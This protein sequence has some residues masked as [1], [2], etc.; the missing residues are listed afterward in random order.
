MPNDPAYLRD[1]WTRTWAGLGTR[2]ADGVLE[3]LLARYEEKHRAYHTL[4]HLTECLSMREKLGRECT[5]PAEVDLALF[6]HDAIYEPMRSDNEA[7]SAAWLDYVATGA[8]LAPDV[9]DRLRA[10]V[11]VTRHDGAP[12]TGDEAVLVDTDLAIL[13]ASEDRFDE[14]D[15]QVRIEYRRVPGFLYRRKRRE[16]LQSFLERDELYSCIAYRDALEVQARL[17]LARAIERLG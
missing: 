10:L 12:A 6:F 11:R 13:G 8:G 2:P 7:Q 5:A 9:R 14:Y 16:V 15:R 1:V 3:Q 17:N 4:Q